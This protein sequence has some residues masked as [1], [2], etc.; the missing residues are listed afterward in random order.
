MCYVNRKQKKNQKLRRNSNISTHTNVLTNEIHEPNEK[1][2]KRDAKNISIL[3][4]AVC[5]S[6]VYA[7]CR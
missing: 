3:P 4:S 6:L 5:I 7:Y 2:V 1:K